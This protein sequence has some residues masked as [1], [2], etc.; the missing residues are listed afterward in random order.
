MT[1]DRNCVV[2][3]FM[4]AS[5]QKIFPLYTPETGGQVIDISVDAS[6][7][8]LILEREYLELKQGVGYWQSMH[9]RSVEREEKLKQKIDELNERVDEKLAEFENH[10]NKL[11][12]LIDRIEMIESKIKKS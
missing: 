4:N 11:K 3:K 10:K 1:P 2:D 12:E 6:P 8:I 7:Q 5:C 9:K